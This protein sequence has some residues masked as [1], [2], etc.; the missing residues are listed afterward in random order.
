MR[1]RSDATRSEAWGFGLGAWALALGARG[2]G[3]GGGMGPS[4]RNDL[5][6]PIKHVVGEGDQAVAL[7]RGGE[8]AEQA[9]LGPISI[10]DGPLVGRVDRLVAGE[11]LAN[12][13]P[14]FG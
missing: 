1:S 2:L 7:G 11:E 14:A 12:G 6:I 13:A 5:P 3:R 8:G 9:A 10:G 4:L